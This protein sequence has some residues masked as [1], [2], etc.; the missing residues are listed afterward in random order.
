[1]FKHSDL[2]TGFIHCYLL[3]TLIE[4]SIFLISIHE[5]KII[6]EKKKKQ[7]RST[8]YSRNIVDANMVCVK[9][10]WASEG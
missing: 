6:N 5:K 7:N 8:L 2:K 9:V 4:I 3:T 10:L 1:M